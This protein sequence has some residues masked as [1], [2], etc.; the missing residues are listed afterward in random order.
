[1]NVLNLK[2]VN[3]VMR[4]GVLKKEYTLK[5]LNDNN[6]DIVYLYSIRSVSGEIV[7]GS[8]NN[9]ETIFHYLRFDFTRNNII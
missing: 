5:Y 9:I 4:L 2:I 1:M 7:N 6:A 8:S 3:M